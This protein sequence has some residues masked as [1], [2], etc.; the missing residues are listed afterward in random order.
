MPV[1]LVAA[2]RNG[3]KAKDTYDVNDQRGQRVQPHTRY[4]AAGPENQAVNVNARQ[5]YAQARQINVCVLRLRQDGLTGNQGGE[6]KQ[7]GK[8]ALPPKMSLKAIW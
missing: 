4:L 2:P 7:H 6:Q 1:C 3:E 8:N 5:Q